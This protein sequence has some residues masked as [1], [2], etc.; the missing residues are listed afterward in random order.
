VFNKPVPAFTFNTVCAGT[1]TS[2][3]ESS[4][5][6]AIDGQQIVSREWDMDF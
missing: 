1:P 2:F 3:I 5:L 6:A 4:T